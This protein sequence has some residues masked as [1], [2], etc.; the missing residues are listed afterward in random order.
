MGKIIIHNL[1]KIY[2]NN[3]D[4]AFELLEQGYSSHQILKQT[5]QAIGILDINIEV[6]EGETFVVMGLSGSG[7]STLIRCLNR[8]IEP[9]KGQVLINGEDVTAMNEKQLR[10]FR[11]HKQAMVFQRFALFPH[12]TVLENAAFGLEIQ[13][14]EKA[15]REKKAMEALQLVGLEGWEHRYPDALSGGM[16]QR[17]GLARALSVDPEIMLMD[18]AFSALDPLIR[19]EMQDELLD[20]QAKMNKT[21]VF[22]THD[23]DEALK[24]GDRIALLKDGFIVQIGSAE[25]ILTK[26]ANDYVAKFVED[27]DVA[28]VLNAGNIMQDPGVLAF[29]NDGPRVALHRMQEAGISSIFVVNRERRLK[30]Y[31]TADLASKAAQQGEK[32]LTNIIQEDYY[33]VSPEDTL[34]KLFD[35]SASSSMPLVV[36]DEDRRLLGVIVR[37]VLIAS[38]VKESAYDT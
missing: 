32:D 27:I 11:R 15:K 16:Q 20:L 28:K 33:A 25:D 5:G 1:S 34:N 10:E 29:E 12:R 30:G 21:I 35:A 26:P 6:S 22:I 36:L 37:G 9:T 18:E 19:R 14:V 13:Q 3:P 23:L 2:G 7:K 4:K 24:I 8:L 38:L 31:I 17:V